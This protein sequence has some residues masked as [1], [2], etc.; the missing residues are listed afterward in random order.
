MGALTAR[1]PQRIGQYWL[2]G[3]LG[4]GGQG[5]V[6]EAYDEQGARVALKVLHASNDPGLRDRFQREVTAAQ[7]V[8]SFCTARVLDADAN[9]DKPYIVS[10]YIEGASLRQV[11]RSG[12]RFT[13]DDLHRLATAIATALTA[14]HDAGVVHRD[15]KPDN[16]L[17][18]ADG[19][20]VIDFG[21]AR[22]EE[23]S[24][25]SAGVVA[26]TPPYIAPEVFTG[27]HA[28]A[29]ADVFAW[30]AIMLFAVTGQDAFRAESLGAT[31]HRVLSLEPDLSALPASMRALVAAALAKDPDARPSARELLLALVSG[32]GAGAAGLLSAGSARARGIRAPEGADPGLGMLAEQAYKALSSAEREL[33]PDVF[34]RLVVIG[35]DNVE[36][37]RPAS[38]ADLLQERPEPERAAVQRILETFSYLISTREEE[39]SLLRPAVLRAWPRLRRWVDADRDGLAILDGLTTA[40]RHWEEHERKDGD[41]LR[42]NRLETVQRWAAAGRRQLTLTRLERTFL[43]ASTRAVTRG[44][45]QR[46]LAVISLV[47]L[48]IG[49]LAG[50]GAAVNAA[51][52]ADV[53]RSIAEGE[54]TKA[55]KQARVALSRQLALQSAE[56]RTAD[57]KI[58]QLLAVTSRHFAPTPEARH[59]MLDILADPAREEL[60]GHT[61]SVNAVAFSPDGTV[62]ATAS[63]DGT[64]RLWDVATRRQVG[65]PL[66]GHTDIVRAVAFSPDGTVLATGGLDKTV[67]LWNVATGRQV[68]SLTGHTEGVNVVA[69]SPDGTVLATGGLDKTVRLWD[70][71]TGRQVGRSLTGH[72][73]SVN[74][75]A[76]S[77][78][79]TVLATGGLDKTVRLWDVATR[80][81]VGRPLTGHTDFVNAVAFSPDGTVLATASDDRTARLWDAATGRQVGQP[82][83]GHTRTVHAVAFGPGGSILATVSDDDTARLWDVATG[84]QLGQPLSGHTDSANAA[85]AF[86]PNGATLATTGRGETVWLWDVATHRQI[87]RSF[88]GPDFARAVAFSPDGTT[89]AIS[90][91]DKSA[92]RLWDRE[93]HRQIGRP[94][95]GHTEFVSAM[96][97]S[98]DGATLVT[99]SDDKSVRIWDGDTHRQVGEL[100]IGP[101]FVSAVA[102]SPNGATLAAAGDDNAVRLW[103]VA[104]RKQVGQPLTGHTRTVNATVFSSDGTTLATVGNDNT[105]RLWSGV[106][107]RQI[108][109][110]LAGRNFAALTLAL[111]PRGTTLATAGDDNAVRLWDVAT[112]KQVGQPLTGHTDVVRAVA[113]SP[114][115]TVL[116]TAGDDGTVRL[117]DVAT[118]RQIGQPLTGHTDIVNAVVFSPDGTVLATTGVDKT[119]RLWEVATPADPFSSLCAIAGR[120][121]TAEEWAQYLPEVS[122]ENVC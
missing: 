115:G 82:L 40:A 106:T 34:L 65:Q 54:R 43:E 95:T 45:R 71:A 32:S 18:A 62:L 50:A 49:A 75:V 6:Y 102:F 2:A 16:V 120:S 22:T 98:P 37:A 69:F 7:R 91:D 12:R 29:A 1:D 84:E 17:L 33:V 96:A 76:F 100:S 117:W 44:V 107:H 24:L 53:Q 4:E 122:Y 110:P 19:P 59:I 88:T 87:G 108:G 41:L 13:G 70:V 97:F 10:E 9:G 68:G 15:L 101:G 92:V 27:R 93:T 74:A 103:D 66:T 57:P 105:I 99:A 113:F 119:V 90:R 104:T 114:D 89:L 77:P 72:N 112:R 73:N 36:T 61:N 42:G 118:R 3:R 52:N 86:S 47:I 121:L 38:T 26:G 80:R 30:G 78:D 64:A 58:A 111:S 31:M 63:D 48:L 67:R 55:E 8:A 83:T 56:L 109:Q 14:V 21:I 5:V 85:V 60:V 79:G 94:L 35:E 11:V 46:R 20:R 116:A 28:E 81:Q 25:S 51:N 23:M 39:I